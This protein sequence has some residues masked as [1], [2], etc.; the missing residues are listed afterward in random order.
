MS[1]SMERRPDPKA[2]TYWKKHDNRNT[3]AR[4]QKEY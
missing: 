3:A 4:W 2:K 1:D